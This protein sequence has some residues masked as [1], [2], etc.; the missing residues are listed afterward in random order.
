MVPVALPRIACVHAPHLPVQLERQR[1]PE[2]AG[3]SL[4][5]S[6][7]PWEPHVILDADDLARD[8]GVVPGLRVSQATRLCPSATVLPADEAA[9]QAL[10][11]LLA[12]A[13]L[14]VTDRL[15]TVGWGDFRLAVGDLGRTYATP[16]ALG[17]ALCKALAVLPGCDARVGLA[18]QRLTAE[19]AA[20]VATPGGW[21]AVAPG[22]ERRFLAAFPISVLPL[23]PETARRLRLLGLDTLGA[24]A[25]V[26]RRA[27]V[28][29]FDATLGFCHDLATG[30]DS[31]PVQP[32][33]LPPVLEA[34]RECE[35]PLRERVAVQLV[36]ARQVARLAETLQHRGYQAQGL[37]LQ[38]V[39]EDGRTN[40]GMAAV[41]PP[42][43]DAA[44]LTRQVERV[45]ES[46]T[47]AGGVTSLLLRLYPLRPAYLGA[48]QL[49][50]FAETRS[51][52]PARL[53]EALRRLR[54]R[55]GDLIITVAALLAPPGPRPIQVMQG[56]TGQV[57]A[58]LW[59]NRFY[60]VTC[61]YEEWRQRRGWWAQP[62]ARDYLRLETQEG[63][64]RVVFHD[65]PTDRWWLE[66]R[67]P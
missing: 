63:L 27:L 24:L 21:I 56:P 6:G 40:T 35:P 51:Q 59:N 12:E 4:L 54:Q 2:L 62:L 37:Q 41:E 57:R 52:L 42:T 33:A 16:A 60:P 58:L 45:L 11:T 22:E 64:V 34:Q 8:A 23:E 14:S 39:D 13:L 50:L 20:E 19:R 49:A 17:Q 44:R 38:L 26:P 30:N 10:H 29:Q 7:R 65:L 25:R 28:A 18:D 5:I 9:Y 32:D 3:R 67:P 48:Q 43:A 61:I 55:F 46:L 15:E 31:R 36:L 1:H 53:L 47:P 66:R